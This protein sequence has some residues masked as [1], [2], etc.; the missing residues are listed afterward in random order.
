MLKIR[1]VGQDDWVNY[2][3]PATEV[4]EYTKT[5]SRDININ[6]ISI[7]SISIINIISISITAPLDRDSPH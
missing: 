2:N 4:Y 6:I 7:I 5:K 1:D 3:P